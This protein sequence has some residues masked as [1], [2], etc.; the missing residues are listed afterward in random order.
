MIKRY[1]K[2]FPHALYGIWFALLNDFGFR[3]QFY[4]IGLVVTLLILFIKPITGTELLFLLL[5]Y[6]LILITELQNSA[7]EIA[8]DKLHPELNEEIGRSKDMAAGAVFLSGLFLFV[9]VVIVFLK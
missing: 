3:T 6:F 8:L 1:L 2:R 9:T 5:A 4:G 7:I